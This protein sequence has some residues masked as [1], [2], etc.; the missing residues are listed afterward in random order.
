MGHPTSTPMPSYAEAWA[1][2]NFSNL[3]LA[4]P[5]STD[6]VGISIIQDTGFP[7]DQLPVFRVR[8]RS[9]GEGQI[10]RRGEGCNELGPETERNPAQL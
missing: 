4:P 1:A 8:V 5:G 2:I 7:Q 10:I 3:D 6:V 9:R